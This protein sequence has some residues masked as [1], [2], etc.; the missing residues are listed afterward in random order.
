MTLQ[1]PFSKPFRS[2]SWQVVVLDCFSKRLIINGLPRPVGEG[3]SQLPK[4][5]G[6]PTHSPC[7]RRER[8][9]DEDQ[10]VVRASLPLSI[11]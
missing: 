1:I 6:E 3:F 5:R 11:G 2:G 8:E 7:F 4:L 9:V 10:P